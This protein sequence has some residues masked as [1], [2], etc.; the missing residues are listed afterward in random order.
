MTK[1]KI[2]LNPKH[3]ERICWGCD[4][5]CPLDDLRCGNGTIRAPHPAEL[6][7][8]EWWKMDPDAEIAEEVT[9]VTEPEPALA[10]T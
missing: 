3:P 8:D 7:G 1:P 6:F 4:K 10:S 2:A 5:F 9:S